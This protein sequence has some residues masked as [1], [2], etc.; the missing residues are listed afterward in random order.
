M[1]EKGQAGDV[2]QVTALVLR[3]WPNHSQQ[4]LS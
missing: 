1:I 4:E 3:L 2:W